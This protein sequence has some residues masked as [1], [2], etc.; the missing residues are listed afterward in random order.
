MSRF[1]NGENQGSIPLK[2]FF[3]QKIWRVS[4]SNQGHGD[5]Q[6]PA[7]PTELQRHLPKWRPGWESNPRPLA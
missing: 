7:L 2:L 1:T 4:E 5:F 6:S 3:K